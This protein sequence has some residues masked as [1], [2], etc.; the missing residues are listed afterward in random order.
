MPEKGFIYF[1]DQTNFPY[2]E[3]SQ[4]E[5]EEIIRHNI[6]LLQDM[7][8]N[9]ILIACNSATVSSRKIRNEFA[10]PTVGVEPGVKVAKDFHAGKKA[11]VLATEITAQKHPKDND[12]GDIRIAGVSELARLVEEHYP[13]IKESDVRAIVDPKFQNS[14]E[15]VVLGCTHYHFLREMLEKMYPNKDF[16]VPEEAIIGQ[17]KRFTDYADSG[18]GDIFLTNGDLKKFQA[19]VEYLTKGQA[20]V[21]KI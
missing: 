5:L 19:K 8:A 6:L 3:K 7:G 11:L 2:G 10:I 4:G 12:Y 17:L 16:I 20:D 21:R 13:N 18:K 9:V 1:A 15:V 14:V